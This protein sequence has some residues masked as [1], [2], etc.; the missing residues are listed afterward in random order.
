M[1]GTDL[2][3]HVPAPSELPNRQSSWRAD[4]AAVWMAAAFLISLALAAGVL[5]KFGAGE[6]GTVQ[7]LRATARWCFVLFWLAYAGGALGK[8]CGPRLA[9]LARRGREFGLAFAAALSVHVALVLWF[10]RVATDPQGAMLFFWAGVFCTYALALFSLPRLRDLLGQRLWR[11]GCELALQYIALVFADDFIF[12]PLQGGGPDKY[13]LSYLPFVIS[14][15]GGVGLRLAGFIW[16]ARA[17]G[18]S[19]QTLTGDAS[20]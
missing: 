4:S 11:I 14:L 3:A 12:E 19:Q 5:A 17:A 10:I 9:V 13:P 16:R 18:Q 8:F 7:A 1:S 6:Q 20:R 15:I 2:T